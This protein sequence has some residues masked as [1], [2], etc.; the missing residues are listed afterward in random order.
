LFL[1][2]KPRRQHGGNDRR[3][4]DGGQQRGDGESDEQQVDHTTGQPPR[5]GFIVASQI[6]GESRDE[7]GGQRAAGHQRE[8]DFVDA[9]GGDVDIES[10]GGAKV[11]ADDDIAYEAEQPTGDKRRHD[12]AGGARDLSGGGGHGAIIPPRKSD[13]HFQGAGH[14][15]IDAKRVKGRC[16]LTLG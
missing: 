10:I 3:R 9:R 11:S 14:L 6:A 13:R 7:G 15:P 4:E 16:P 1:R 2:A 8:D 12:D 5:A